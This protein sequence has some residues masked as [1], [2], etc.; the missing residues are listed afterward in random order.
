MWQF[1]E[2][3]LQMS[4]MFTLA[5]IDNRGLGNSSCPFYESKIPILLLL[6]L[7]LSHQQAVALFPVP[8]VTLKQKQIKN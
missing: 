5:F 6:L 7:H 8:T 4:P 1:Q 3:S 2:Q